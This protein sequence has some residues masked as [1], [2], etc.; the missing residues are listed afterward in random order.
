MKQ[1]WLFA[2][3]MLLA[4]CSQPTPPDIWIGETTRSDSGVTQELQLQV[5]VQGDRWLGSYTVDAV[6]GAFDGTLHSD[7]S[8][9]A[10]LTPGPDCTYQLTG[11]VTVGALTAAYSPLDC[12]GGTAGTWALIRQ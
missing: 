1:V 9:E 10:T 4:A 2:A 8:L 11:T 6:R 3:L 7:G 5:T 12:A